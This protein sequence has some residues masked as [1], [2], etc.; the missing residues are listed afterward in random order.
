MSLQTEILN[1]FSGQA[2]EVPLYLPDL[3]LWYRWHRERGTLPAPWADDSLPQVARAMGVPAW[4]TARPW[5]VETAGVRVETVEREGERVTRWETAAGTLSARWTVGPD[6]DWWQAEHLVKGQ[7]DL[8]AAVELAR[9]RRYVLDPTPLDAARAE[10]G[11][12]G[13]V[14]LEIPRRPYSDLLHDF[15][16]WGEGLFLLG[17]PAVVEILR[18][19]EG[20]LH[21][22][23]EQVL[24][25]P[26]AVVFAM[27][28]LDGQYISPRAFD[29][30]L[31][32][33]Y[34]QTAQAVHRRDKRLLVH[35][36][37]PIRHLL[38]PLAAAGVDGVEGVAGPPQGDAS[39]AEARALAGPELTLW[40]G[41]PQDVVLPTVERS[42]YEA[43]VEGALREA[44]GDARVLLGVADRVPPDADVE[45]VQEIASLVGK[46]RDAPPT[47][48]L[49]WGQTLQQP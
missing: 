30:H 17:E 26:G 13:V 35:C 12:E 22:F 19:L 28:N 43:A 10:V 2:R 48:C 33:S 20:V 1:R 46:Y 40:G 36:G 7:A 15:L 49:W 32:A 8:A 38:A 45:R 5:R 31:A 16:G 23:V 14:A 24:E 39:L 3:T 29:R 41:I 27:D 9:A 44:A 11:E 37:G 18:A 47:T 6:G 4:M 42:A 21:P 34:R 25:L